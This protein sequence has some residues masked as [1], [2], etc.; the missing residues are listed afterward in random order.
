MQKLAEYT[1]D[2]TPEAF[3]QLRNSKLQQNRLGEAY[4]VWEPAVLVYHEDDPA[5]QHIISTVDMRDMKAKHNANVV[6]VLG[7]LIPSPRVGLLN[8]TWGLFYATGDKKFLEL[9]FETMGNR[10]SNNSVKQAALKLFQE[11]LD[12]YG[13]SDENAWSLA[14]SEV[15][16]QI[17]LQKQNLKEMQD[18][19]VMS[20]YMH[21]RKDIPESASLAG[22]TSEEPEKPD[23]QKIKLL[24]AEKLFDEVVTDM[25]S[26]IH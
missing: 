11:A 13:D 1:A 16:A 25:M 17:A 26:K 23:A 7:K 21:E 15:H 3:Q 20:N 12:F 5:W 14:V 18:R 8:K 2:P 4:T 22:F 10:R 9:A 19:G 24:E 6:E